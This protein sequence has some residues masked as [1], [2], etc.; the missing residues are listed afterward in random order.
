MLEPPED[1]MANLKLRRNKRYIVTEPGHFGMTMRYV[2]KSEGG[3]LDL[4]VYWASPD[5]GLYLSDKEVDAYVEPY[6]KARDWQIEKEAEEWL[7]KEAAA[8]SGAAK[9]G[10]MARKT[11][12]ISKASDKELRMGHEALLKQLA[13]FGDDGRSAEEQLCFQRL[14]NIKAE[15]CRRHGALSDIF[16]F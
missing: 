9:E 8:Q 12:S 10:R 1:K 13:S 5:S 7:E 2:G 4:F 15:I 16:G 11:L 6:T 14:Q 3:K